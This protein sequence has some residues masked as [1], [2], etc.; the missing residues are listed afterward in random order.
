MHVRIADLGNGS[1]V[2]EWTPFAAGS[3]SVRILVNSVETHGSPFTVFA[4]I[5][6]ASQFWKGFGS[7]RAQGSGIWGLGFTPRPNFGKD[8]VR[9]GLKAHLGAH[10]QRQTF[11]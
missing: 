10:L 3:Y 4:V 2:G 8:L 1:W 9:L 11:C 6:P 7:F 5:N